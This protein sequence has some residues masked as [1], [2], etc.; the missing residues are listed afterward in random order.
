MT[1]YSQPL[2]ST[3]RHIVAARQATLVAL[4]SSSEK[5]PRSASALSINT[6]LVL[7]HHSFTPAEGCRSNI[8]PGMIPAPSRINKVN[9]FQAGHPGDVLWVK[10]LCGRGFYS[11]VCQN[12]SDLTA[13]TILPLSDYTNKFSTQ[14]G[15]CGCRYFWLWYFCSAGTMWDHRERLTTATQKGVLIFSVLTPATSTAVSWTS[16]TVHQG[17]VHYSSSHK[18][19][20]MSRMRAHQHMCAR[21]HNTAIHS[22]A[23]SEECGAFMVS[24]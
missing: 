12:A 6:T 17:W 7:K 15:N 20:L 24:L 4:R 9:D 13:N 1:L 3:H 10:L 19:C 8:H 22:S 14:S 16:P 5:P 21:I 11:S 2:P 18:N 23:M